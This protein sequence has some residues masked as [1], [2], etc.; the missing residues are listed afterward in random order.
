MSICTVDVLIAS[1]FV[2]FSAVSLRFYKISAFSVCF[3]LALTTRLCDDGSGTPRPL[4]PAGV[5]CPDAAGLRGPVSSRPGG[6][7]AAGRPAS[8]LGPGQHLPCH[9]AAVGSHGSRSLP[10]H[11]LPPRPTCGHPARRHV[12][13]SHPRHDCDSSRREPFRCWSQRFG[14][15]PFGV[16]ESAARGEGEEDGQGDVQGGE[17]MD[18]EF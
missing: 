12:P 16:V 2:L 13:D 10:P 6:P 15:L 17:L 4:V 3:S 18:E 11:S 9:P 14:S 8:H 1:S 7:G 5:C